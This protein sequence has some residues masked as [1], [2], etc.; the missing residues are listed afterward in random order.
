MLLFIEGIARCGMQGLYKGMPMP[1]K[2]AADSA[3]STC[4]SRH[5]KPPFTLPHLAAAIHGPCSFCHAQ[6]STNWQAASIMHATHT[7]AQTR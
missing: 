4:T 1:S 2:Q 6:L 5:G 3:N 7:Q